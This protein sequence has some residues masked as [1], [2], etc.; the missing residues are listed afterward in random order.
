M[1]CLSLAAQVQCCACCVVGACSV[2]LCGGPRCVCPRLQL[3]APPCACCA[4]M[5]HRRMLLLLLLLLSPLHTSTP[6]T[7]ANAHGCM[8]HM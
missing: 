3:P 5:V 2:Q 1:F 8:L 7:Y 4:F 6:C